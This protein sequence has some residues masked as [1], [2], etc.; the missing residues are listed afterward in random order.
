M[1]VVWLDAFATLE[2][3]A[4]PDRSYDGWCTTAEDSNRGL[5][6][7]KRLFS[8][9]MTGRRGW[10]DAL[11]SSLRREESP[12]FEGRLPTFLIGGDYIP[13]LLASSPLP[14][15]KPRRG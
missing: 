5:L 2:N 6:V 12:V 15:Q 7:R 11:S 1:N 14:A 9:K 10:S 8:W 4:S 3:K 13:W